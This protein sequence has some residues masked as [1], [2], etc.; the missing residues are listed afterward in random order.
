MIFLRIP[1]P[2]RSLKV[3][4]SLPSSSPCPS[5]TFCKDTLLYSRHSNYIPIPR[6]VKLLK[7]YLVR[8]LGREH[9]NS[10][11]SRI[12]LG[13]PRYAI[14]YCYILCLKRYCI[15]YFIPMF[16]LKMLSILDIRQPC[17]ISSNGVPMIHCLPFGFKV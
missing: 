17:V 3:S 1:I 13:T 9:C 5:K 11:N 14:I 6:K 2:L 4:A 15:S 8:D 12:Y 7:L 10:I 16:N